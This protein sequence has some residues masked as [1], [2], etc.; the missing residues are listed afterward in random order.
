MA[1]TVESTER[2]LRQSGRD[3]LIDFYTALRSLKLY[4]VEN[5]QVQRALDEVTESAN[6]LLGIEDEL[7]VK[8][9]GEFIFVNA[10]RLRLNLDNF[11]SFSH[12]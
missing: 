2:V 11:A 8:V 5:E 9:S 10:T 12:V 1:D 3:F 7:E 6:T 4:P